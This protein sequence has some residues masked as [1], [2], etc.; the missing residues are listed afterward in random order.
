M[1]VFWMTNGFQYCSK[2]VRPRVFRLPSAPQVGVW[3]PCQILPRSISRLRAPVRG[4]TASVCSRMSG[5]TATC[6]TK[7]RYASR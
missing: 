1:P 2:N 3:N 7:V 4:E 5:R 6:T